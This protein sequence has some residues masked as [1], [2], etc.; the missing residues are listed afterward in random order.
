MT[1]TCRDG[2]RRVKAAAN[3]VPAFRT[4]RVFDAAIAQK[5]VKIV[6]RRDQ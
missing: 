1:D 4:Y 3:Y 6:R 2:V 5:G